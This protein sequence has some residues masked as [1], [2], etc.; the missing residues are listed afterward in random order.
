ML[1]SSSSRGVAC[2]CVVR[3]SVAV[4]R[5]PSYQGG[6]F[7]TMSEDYAERGCDASG[8]SR[9]TYTTN[10]DDAKKAKK[11]ITG[12]NDGERWRRREHSL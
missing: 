10:E 6:I 11:R 7:E 12:A 1:I 5:Q 9:W 8:L 4:T 2:G 3:L